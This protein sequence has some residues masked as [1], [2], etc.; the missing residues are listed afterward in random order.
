MITSVKFTKTVD[1]NKCMKL[2]K[3]LNG[4]DVSKFMKLNKLSINDFR[5]MQECLTELWK[6]AIT[7]TFNESVANVF[8]KYGFLVELDENNINY[9]I[10]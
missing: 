8:K 7:Y 3:I 5:V 6:N 4:N 9:V 1:G 2:A 10:Q